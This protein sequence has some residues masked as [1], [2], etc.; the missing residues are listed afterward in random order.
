MSTLFD[1]LKLLFVHEYNAVNVMGGTKRCKNELIPDTDR[2]LCKPENGPEFEFEL[3][4]V[5][6]MHE[7]KPE[8]MVTETS[9]DCGPVIF[10]KV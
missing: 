8:L 7:C 10:L 3:E 5:Y 6:R 9:L 1:S 4:H 2:I